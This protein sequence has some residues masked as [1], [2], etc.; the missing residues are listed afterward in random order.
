M[1]KSL[2]VLTATLLGAGIAA[3]QDIYVTDQTSDQLTV[4]PTGGGATQTISN[5]VSQSFLDAPTGI[6]VDSDP[7][8]SYYGDV[9]VANSADN[10]IVTYDPTTGTFATFAND[11]TNPG[12]LNNPEGLAFDSNGNLYVANSTASGFIT[13]FSTLSTAVNTAY[14]TGLANP[15][16]VS[17]NALNQLF[18]S[19]TGNAGGLITIPNAG[20]VNAFNPS[21]SPSSAPTGPEGVTIGPNGDLYVVYTNGGSSVAGQVTL[22]GTGA[23]VVSSLGGTNIPLGLIFDE[24]KNLYVAD[25]GANLVTE[26]VFA[27]FNSSTGLYTYSS[28]ATFPT[29]TSSGPT[30]LAFD[31]VSQTVPEPGTYAML[32]GGLAALYVMQRR[33]TAAPVQA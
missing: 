5:P 30:F 6:A 14:A 13:Q 9:F 23:V 28:T 1:K 22:G 26:Y 3:A 18:V 21:F 2:L 11:S 10:T 15:Y 24:N 7:S 29:G 8:S 25:F 17:A 32:F 33:R 19:V 20:N 27:G 4:I 31:P 12:S 16:G